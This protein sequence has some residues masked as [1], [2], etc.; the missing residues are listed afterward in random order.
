MKTVMK[1]VIEKHDKEFNKMVFLRWL[2]DNRE[3]LLEAEKEQIKEAYMS[4]KHDSGI[5][6]QY[7]SEQYYQQTYKSEQ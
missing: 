3:R 2:S 5:D 4:G 1:E 6:K 7:S